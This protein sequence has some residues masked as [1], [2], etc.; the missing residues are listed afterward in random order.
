MEL[1]RPRL[2]A[3]GTTAIERVLDGRMDAIIIVAAPRTLGEP[4]KHYHTALSAV[5]VGEISQDLTGHSAADVE[6]TISAA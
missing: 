3:T 2:P 6:S 1:L 5:R 4:R